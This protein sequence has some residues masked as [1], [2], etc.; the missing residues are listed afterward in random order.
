MRASSRAPAGFSLIEILVVISIIGLLMGLS[1]FAIGKYRE[2]GRISD[3]K[4]RIQ[5]LALRCESYAERQG[6]FPPSRL[7]EVG[8]KDAS[9][10]VNQGIEA[11]VAALRDERY[12]GLRPDE[13]TLGNSDDD[14]SGMLRALDGTSALLEV[15]DPWDNPFV[16]IVQSD[17]E[18]SFVVRLSDGSLAEDVE[19]RAA[20]NE[21]TGAFH[22]FESYQ[23]L[24]AGPDGLLDTE[25]DL[26]NYEISRLGP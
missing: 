12:A 4:S 8:V 26:A 6:D 21:L 20:T 3:C 5:N 10:E 23:I 13:R 17:Y 2:T 22:H 14:S 18:R 24:S 11:L 7:V 9:N 1:A 16:Y 25:D 19:A 15:L